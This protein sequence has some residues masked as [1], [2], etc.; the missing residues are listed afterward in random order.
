MPVIFDCEKKQIAKNPKEV[1]DFTKAY[2][3]P[4][5]KDAFKTLAHIEHVYTSFPDGKINFQSLEIGGQT[6]EQL[7]QALERAGIKISDYARS[8][9]KG[10]DFTTAKR[11]EQNDLVRLTVDALFNDG[12]NHTTDEIYQKAK[13]FGLELCPAEVGPHL[14]LNYQDQPLGEWVYVAMKQITGSDGRPFIFCV[15]RP[16]VGSW[17]YGSWAEPGGEW[18]P[19]YEFVFRLRK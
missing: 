8:M 2:I 9:M 4:L 19:R 7:E 15:G 12:R 11:K 18:P 6:K 5:F 10:K 17:L 1:N 13:D 14:R 3:G 16:E